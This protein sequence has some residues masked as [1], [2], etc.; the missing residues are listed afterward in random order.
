MLQTFGH[1]RN[2]ALMSTTKLLALLCCVLSLFV[3]VA[4]HAAAVPQPRAA[5]MNCAEMVQ[6]VTQHQMR[7]Q[8]GPSEE[9]GCCPD[10]TLKCLVTMNCLSPLAI[11]GASAQQL[12]TFRFAPAYLPITVGTLASDAPPP[13]SPPPQSSRI[14]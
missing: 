12:A 5:G 1:D 7:D 6:G 9:Q 11:A 4:A 10:M 14:A 8:E 3:Q 13:E 2:G